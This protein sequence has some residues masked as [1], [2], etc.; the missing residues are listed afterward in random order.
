LHVIFLL[1]KNN[2]ELASLAQSA[3]HSTVVHATGSIS[4]EHDSFHITQVAGSDLSGT[5][6]S[7]PNL[8][9]SDIISSRAKFDGEAVVPD[10]PEAA[11]YVM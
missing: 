7:P 10:K 2:K 11:T 3:R 1:E 4:L 9:A 5:T 6:A 8:A